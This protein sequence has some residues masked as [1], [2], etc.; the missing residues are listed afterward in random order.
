MTNLEIKINI[1]NISEIRSILRKINARY[2]FQMEQKDTYFKLGNNKIKTREINDSEIQLIKYF[3]KEV[4]GKKISTYTIKKISTS[5]RDSFLKKNKILCEIYKKRELWIYKNTR[6]HIDKVEGLGKFLELET[7]LKNISK[8][9]GNTEFN[10]LISILGVNKDKS[11]PYSY[12]DILL[13]ANSPKTI[14]K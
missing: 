2:Q 6:V 9:E 8:K 14:I 3:R 11:I 5:Q 7:V 4:K 1:N 12:S 13:S 10:E